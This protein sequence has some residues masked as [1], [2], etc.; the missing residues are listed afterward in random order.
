MKSKIWVMTMAIGVLTL[1]VLP[2]GVSAQLI[3]NADRG[4]SERLYG[5]STKLG[6]D[7]LMFTWDP[8]L[9]MDASVCGLAVFCQRSDQ[10]GTPV[11]NHKAT[12][13]KVKLTGVDS[14]NVLTVKKNA[15]VL[16]RKGLPKSLVMIDLT[17]GVRSAFASDSLILVQGKVT[18][19]GKAK[20]GDIV[21]CGLAMA[22]ISMTG[23][24]AS[25]KAQRVQVLRQVGATLV[26]PRMEF[27][28]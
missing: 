18:M 28:E 4:L 3:A 2:M 11:G 25:T 14:L 27:R 19:T 9:P 13:K 15:K 8:E 5:S 21:T 6:T 12:F 16:I 24:Q 22:E 7:T 20:A 10:F 26:H 23:A 17:S 1:G